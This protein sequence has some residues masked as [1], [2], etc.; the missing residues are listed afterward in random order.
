M[1]ESEK[2]YLS[3]EKEGFLKGNLS[4]FKTLI[5]TAGV[6]LLVGSQIY[7]PNKRVIEAIVG[8]ILVLMLWNFSALAATWL[9][10]ISYP[11]PFSISWGN[12]NFIFILIILLTYLV[13]VSTGHYKIH[14]DKTISLPLLLIIASYIL[15]FINVP[16]EAEIM[17]NTFVNIANFLATIVFMLLIFNVVNDEEKLRKTV[18]II[19]ITAALVILFTIVEMFFPGKVII[20][21]W[22]YTTHKTKLVMKGLRMM[23][24]FHSYELHGEFLAINA[25]LIFF[26]LVRSRGMAIKIL[27]GMLLIADLLMLFATITR[28]AF[29]SFI[30]GIIYLIFLS[31]K[32][33]NITRFVY[34]VAAIVIVIITLEGF[35]ANY[36]TSG[37][38]FDR[39][40]GT[41]F[42]KGF[43]PD[44]RTGLWE[45]AFERGM[46]HPIFGQGVGWDFTKTTF[47]DIVW[48]HNLYLFYFNI[49]GL[50]GLSAFLFLIYRLVRKTF[51]GLKSSI[52]TSPF[53]E[54]FMKILHI[55]IIIFLFDQLKIEYLR[56]NKY[57]FFIWLIFGLIAA[58][59]NVIDKN[60]REREMPAP[61]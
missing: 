34:L 60:R 42:S 14:L 52:V 7:N 8:S 30:L 13:R 54:A 22:L 1:K 19:M 59:K 40:I 56:N 36:T 15:S 18:N 58:T 51:A 31:R 24:P 28:G 37:S 5:I 29:F 48:P 9:V 20:P 38:L 46:K 3:R 6:G 12:S 49:T 17:K 10:I 16:F 2:N 39:V 27:L 11:F 57:T 33:L 61:S 4:K 25:F 35:V 50:F 53:P 45:A 47:K 41:T 21:N 32:E 26:K 23:G 55:V 43:V 44:S